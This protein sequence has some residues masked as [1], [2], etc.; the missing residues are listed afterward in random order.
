MAGAG[1]IQKSAKNMASGI[2]YRVLSLLTAF[3]VRTVFL[4]YLNTDYLSVNGLYSSVLSML[5][6]AELGFSTAMVYNMYRPLAEKDYQK[7]RQLMLLYKRVYA[8]IGTVI[9]V[10]GLCVVPFL[11]VIIKNKPDLPGLTFYYLLF[12]GDSVLSYWFF[13]YRTSILQADQR[14]YIVTNYNGIFNLIKSFLQILLLVLTHNFT[15]YLLTQIGCTIAQ[16]VVIAIRVGK[17]YPVFNKG[18]N[19]RLPA[20]EKRAIFKDVKALMLQK[21]SFRVLNTSDSIIISAFVGV[22]W[23]GLLSNYLMVE[24]AVVAVLSQITGAITASLGNYF[25]VED[26]EAGYTLFRRIEFMNYFFYSFSA[27]ALITLLTPF[28]TVWLGVDYTLS[29]FIVIALIARFY[30]E[31]YMNIMSA[32]R[33]TLGLFVQGQYLPLVVAALNIALSIGLSFP[34][35]VAGVLLATPL[36]RLC[37]NAWFMPYV[38]HKHGFHKPVVP[39]Y[40]RYVG[41]IALVVII[42]IMMQLLSNAIFTGGVTIIKFT[43]MTVLTGVLPIL[44]LSAA[45]YRT[46]EFRY[47]MDLVIGT[48]KTRILHRG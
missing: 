1:R 10:L 47:F 12:L 17:E 25:A 45:F 23:V 16:N 3:V 46:D 41:R 38:I 29:R 7:L 31:G 2:A 43:A 19:D 48:V 11:D 34:F 26:R 33:S 40:L 4:H 18:E 13:A 14:A 21:V 28:I 35:G 42:T 5:S 15:V 24:E 30:V 37:I 27:I 44:L 36:A 32:F 8:V 39:F 9:L 6:L 22:N 20:E